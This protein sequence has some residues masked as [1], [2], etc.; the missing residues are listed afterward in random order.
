MRRELAGNGWRAAFSTL[1]VGEAN[2]SRRCAYA[3]FKAPANQAAV[4]NPRGANSG[5][6]SSKIAPKLTNI[7]QLS[8]INGGRLGRLTAPRPAKTL[9]FSAFAL[10]RQAEEMKN[11]R[12]D[13]SRHGYQP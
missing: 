12:G 11:E 4:F 3:M 13:I 6:I 1:S 7:G 2:R 9:E 5:R 10:A 8:G